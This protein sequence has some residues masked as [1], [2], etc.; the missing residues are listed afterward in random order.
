M[1]TKSIQLVEKLQ[2]RH[3]RPT[4]EDKISYICAMA[5]IRKTEDIQL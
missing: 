5:R 3:I 1:S 2:V 4:K